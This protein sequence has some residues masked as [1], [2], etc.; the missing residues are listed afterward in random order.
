MRS[1]KNW[2]LKWLRLPL[3]LRASMLASAATVHACSALHAL[4]CKLC[5]HMSS[6]VTWLSLWNLIM[7]PLLGITQAMVR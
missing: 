7:F 5:T 3:R 4:H 6:D 2:A 1:L